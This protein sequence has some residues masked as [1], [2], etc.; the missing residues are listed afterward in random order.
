[1]AS[2]PLS[3]VDLFGPPPY[4][5]IVEDV[6]GD[7]V[8]MFLG[9]IDAD[10]ANQRLAR[11][12]WWSPGL[13]VDEHS[14]DHALVTFDVHAPRCAAAPGAVPGRDCDCAWDTW[15]AW[16]YRDAEPG[17]PAAVEVTF[18]ELTREAIAA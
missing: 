3:P 1:M 8:E 7:G 16:H 10:T 5:H 15:I 14:L 9:H 11:Q 6:Y 17:D 18:A 4:D 12:P 2:E 13:V